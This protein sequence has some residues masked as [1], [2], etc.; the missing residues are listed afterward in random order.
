[1]TETEVLRLHKESFCRALQEQDFATLEQLYSDSYRL[2]RSDGSVLTKQQ[3]LEDLR[4]HGLTFQSID[5]FQEQV[6]L[7]GS[8]AILTGESRTVARRN[9]MESRAHF[10]LIAVYA[11]EGAVIR[12]VYFQSTDCG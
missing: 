10:R 9:G 11:R 7:F 5:L 4:D 1:M 3:V 6:R 8:V 12:L 2:V